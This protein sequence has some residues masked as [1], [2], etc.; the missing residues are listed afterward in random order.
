MRQRIL[1][2]LGARFLLARC[3]RLYH[4]VPVGGHA[5]PH[6]SEAPLTG[7]FRSMAAVLDVLVGV[8][9]DSCSQKGVADGPA[10]AHVATGNRG[11]PC[12][13]R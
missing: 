6:C 7:M 5:P 2:G 3:P 13:R 12:N 10:E 11:A 4:P 8:M 1:A 9:G